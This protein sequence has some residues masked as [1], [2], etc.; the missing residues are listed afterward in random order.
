LART[1]PGETRVAP[2]LQTLWGP[3]LVQLGR[4]TKEAFPIIYTFPMSS[5]MHLISYK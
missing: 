3:S 5:H 2:P 1:H 4:C